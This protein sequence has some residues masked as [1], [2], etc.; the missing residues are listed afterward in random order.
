MR[1]LDGWFILSQPKYKVPCIFDLHQRGLFNDR[2]SVTC[3][4]GARLLV[5]EQ[6][7]VALEYRFLVE[8]RGVRNGLLHS[9]A[10]RQ[11]I[12]QLAEDLALDLTALHGAVADEETVQEISRVYSQWCS[13]YLPIDGEGKID[14]SALKQKLSNGLAEAKKQIREE[15]KRRNTDW[16][17]KGV[18]TLTGGYYGWRGG[19]TIKEMFLAYQEAEG[20]DDQAGFIRKM[21][22][23]YSVCLT[24]EPQGLTRPDGV[25]WQNEDEIWECWLS[26]V[27]SEEEAGRVMGAME[28]VLRPHGAA[29]PG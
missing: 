8:D 14:G 26:F 17:T 29:S 1:P 9:H 15:L 5:N 3:R 21:A 4:C 11:G 7:Q 27:G 12:L 24:A 18:A 28:S 20:A 25:V 6:L 13:D 19:K 10:T 16:V 22:Q 2:P 23:F